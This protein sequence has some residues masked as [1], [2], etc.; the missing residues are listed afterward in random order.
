MTQLIV[1]RTQKPYYDFSKSEVNKGY[2][3]VLSVA[4]RTLQNREL[5]SIS[6]LMLNHIKNVGDVVLTTG[7]V[8]S[9]C[10]F[11]TDENTDT[12]YLSEGKIYYN[13]IVL[14]TPLGQWETS[15]ISN[16]ICYICFELIETA[17]TEIDDKT[18]YDPAENYEN[19]NEPGSYRL[20]YTIIPLIYN[21]NELKIA[22]SGSRTV[23]D[24]I[25]LYNKQVVS[26]TKPKPVLGKIYDMMAYRTFDESGNFLVRGLK[27]TTSLHTNSTS[28]YKISLSEGRAYV[29]GYEYNYD[30]NYLVTK[31]AID[32]KKSDIPESHQYL[33]DINT[34]TLFHKN[35]KEITKIICQVTQQKV[36]V[37]RGTTIS[38]T[39]NINGLISIDRVYQ[40]DY[41]YLRNVDYVV[42]GLS[43]TWLKN[44]MPSTGSTYYID[45][46]YKKN[47]IEGVDFIS[48]VEN[49]YT[50]ITLITTPTFN[51]Q[52]EIDYTWY[53]SRYD[54]V[55]LDISG[56]LK[57]IN[58]NPGELNEID[59]PEIPIGV[60][61]IGYILIEPSKDPSSYKKIHYNIYRVTVSDQRAL[62]NRVDNIEYNI[63]MTELENDMQTK[64]SE[65]E[66]LTNLK[67]VF[68]DSFNDYSKSDIYNMS[69]SASIDI[70]NN[71]MK[72]GLSSE[73]LSYTDL[74]LYYLSNVK[75]S[76][77]IITL[78]YSTIEAEWQKIASNFID[79]NK[80]EKF[81]P[82][83]KLYFESQQF[84]NKINIDIN[85]FFNYNIIVPIKSYHLTSKIREWIYGFS[86]D[87]NYNIAILNNVKINYLKS[88]ELPIMYDDIIILRG[89]N[90]TPYDSIK[91]NQLRLYFDGIQ[92][93]NFDILSENFTNPDDEA[94]LSLNGMGNF[95][96]SKKGTFKIEFALPNNTV[97][98]NKEILVVRCEKIRNSDDTITWHEINEIGNIYYKMNGYDK[99]YE[100]ISDIQNDNKILNTFYINSYKQ[101]S[102]YIDNLTGMSSSRNFDPISQTFSFS[103]DM[104][105]D[106]LDLYFKSK[107]V[108]I[109]DLENIYVSIREVNNNEP[110][111]TILYE[112][113]FKATDIKVSTTSATP[114]NIQFNYPIYCQ[115][116]KEYAFSI[117]VPRKG[118]EIW[119]AKVNSNN[120]TSKSV[121]QIKPYGKGNLYICN[122]A[123][124]WTLLQDASLKFSIHTCEFENN[125]VMETVEY[126]IDKYAMM[127]TYLESSIMEGTELTYQ[128]KID[129]NEY[130]GLPIREKIIFDPNMMI[131]D[132]IK[133]K[134]RFEFSTNNKKIS[135]VINWNTF[136]TIFAKY[137]AIGSYIMRSFSFSE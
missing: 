25:K 89:E 54:L 105:I 79:I 53:I 71:I 10:S 98:G 85:N 45:I 67:G 81:Y 112:H 74:S 5:N 31:S 108:N 90:F 129:E 22:Q 32:T 57:V 37:N 26:P 92:I 99:E 102:N 50:K 48:T 84:N 28:Q 51:T 130:V 52:M 27:I 88:L 63:T 134:F 64:H 136:N 72:L 39:L 8:I 4:G 122:N 30:N 66:S 16:E 40:G 94:S 69:Y 58:G 9:G 119:Y 24:I 109:N 23:I 103:Q 135:P 65:K 36:N 77:G 19:Y 1:D 91:D 68:V 29:K 61:P 86:Q 6:G 56:L 133:I 104:F 15:K 34:Y 80:N 18:L 107:P 76:N 33:E 117:N 2:I 35:V 60:L 115:S 126:A 118:Y 14:N 62:I 132:V 106:K 49:N 100:R 43:I 114:T 83:P 124:T 93:T 3:S 97:Q 44:N 12:S 21:E 137:N 110:S 82:M 116:G 46:V 73:T 111:G 7:T 96:C 38:D 59:I 131:N 128:Y 47:F 13:G 113:W 17:A 75:N 125:G 78:P 127:N 42:N 55:Y 123:A 20:L 120:I 95:K 11:Y 41:T 87:D 70:F 101:R 121:I